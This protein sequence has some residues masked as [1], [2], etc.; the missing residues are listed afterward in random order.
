MAQED[1][2]S[3]GDYW[4]L[5][6]ITGALKHARTRWRAGHQRHAEYGSV[7]FPLRGELEKIMVTLC[8]AL[9]PLRLGPHFVRL[10]NEDAFEPTT[11]TR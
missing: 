5:D 3:N 7:G 6:E 4:N 8:A 11:A 10:E 1:G 2:P 9:F